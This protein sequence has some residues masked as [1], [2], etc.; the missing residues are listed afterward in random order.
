MRTPGQAAGEFSRKIG[1]R[2][3]WIREIQDLTL[4]EIQK[5]SGVQAKTLQRYERGGISIPA[6][7]IEQIAAALNVSPTRL[8]GPLADFAW[9]VQ[10]QVA[11]LEAPNVLI[12]KDPDVSKIA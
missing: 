11:Q 10:E 8:C 12:S 4:A 7:Q 6:N 5:R 1:R 3:R 9:L 2:L